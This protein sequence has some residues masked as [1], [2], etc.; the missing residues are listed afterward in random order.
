M[1]KPAPVAQALAV[2][3]AV[4][5]T[6]ACTSSTMIRSR[7]TGAK[8]YLNGAYAGETPYQM[9]DSK[10]VGSTTRVR[11]EH[12]GYEP[13]DA[14]ISRNEEVDGLALVGGLFFLIPFL[15]VMEYQPDH[16]YELR[17]IPV[18]PPQPVAGAAAPATTGN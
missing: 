12:P 14:W 17:A 18:L 3:A 16:T 4:S 1:R 5:L 9:S 13:L 15:W 2:L 10:I 8:V 11:L 6:A 7:P